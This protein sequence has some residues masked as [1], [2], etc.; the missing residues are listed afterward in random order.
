MEDEVMAWFEV[1]PI[2]KEQIAS[3][4]EKILQDL[5]LDADEKVRI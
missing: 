4:W 2:L 3:V 1:V 5:G